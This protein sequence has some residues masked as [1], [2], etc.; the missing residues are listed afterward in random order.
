ME[1]SLRSA[2]IAETPD[3]IQKNIDEIDGIRGNIDTLSDEFSETILSDDVKKAYEEFLVTR[4]N[5][6]TAL[7]KTL[8]SSSNRT[9]TQKPWKC[10]E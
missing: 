7:E 10:A 2:I 6:K 5:Y 9:E 8:V 4:Q 3:E 1:S